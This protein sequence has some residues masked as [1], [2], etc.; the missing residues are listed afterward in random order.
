MVFA[1]KHIAEKENKKYEI[2]DVGQVGCY[3]TI[4]KENELR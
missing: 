2:T 1:T 4:E 3:S